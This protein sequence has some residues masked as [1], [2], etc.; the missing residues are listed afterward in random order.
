MKVSANHNSFSDSASRKIHRRG[1]SGVFRRYKKRVFFKTFIS[2]MVLYLT[3]LGI[4][5]FSNNKVLSTKRNLSWSKTRK[6]LESFLRYVRCIFKSVKDLTRNAIQNIH[7]HDDKYLLWGSCQ[8][9][10]DVSHCDTRKFQ[11]MKFSSL[12]C[13]I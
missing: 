9:N 8:F 10:E 2:S 1:I 3:P 11:Q 5:D 7:K 6:I 13:N 12:R 4:S